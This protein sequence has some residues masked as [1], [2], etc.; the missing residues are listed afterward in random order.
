M[1]EKYLVLVK[2]MSVVIEFLLHKNMLER[3]FQLSH[4]LCRL[5]IMFSQSPGRGEVADAGPWE[6][7]TL[8]GPFPLR[9][10][11]VHALFSL[12][13]QRKVPVAHFLCSA[14][15]LFHNLLL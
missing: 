15:P 8:Q 9:V 11:M 10:Q 13:T 14:F 2:H 1:I 5:R 4:L 6:D 3:I 12:L 7:P